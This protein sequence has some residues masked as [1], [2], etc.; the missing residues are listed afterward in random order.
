MRV[1]LGS[2]RPSTN[3]MDDDSTEV[4]AARREMIEATIVS[5]GVR[6]PRVIAAMT[7]V[8]RHAFVPPA[9]RSHAHADSALPLVEGQTI[10]QP[11][12]VA[13]MTEALRLSP[14]QRC[15]EVGTGSGYQTAVLLEMGATVFSVESVPQVAAMGRDNLLH[16]GY[17]GERLELLEADGTGG[18]PERAPFDR[19]IVTAAPEEVPAA[20]L[21][22]LAVGGCMALPVGPQDGVQQLERWTRVAVGGAPS[23][24]HREELFSVRFVPLLPV[25]GR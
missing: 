22:Q 12:V 14:G 3:D 17:L 15:L 2:D 13:A 21:E 16:A 20:L 10:S 19:I 4:G 23:A 5:R 25:A 7:A 24:F 9:L 8:P 1:S 11:F 18:W 6:D